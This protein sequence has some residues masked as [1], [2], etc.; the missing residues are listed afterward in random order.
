MNINEDSLIEDDSFSN[1]NNTVPNKEEDINE[2]KD[3]N[4]IRSIVKPSAN[5]VENAF[6]AI[7][8]LYSTELST[9]D[10]IRIFNSIITEQDPKIAKA[11]GASVN[12][13]EGLNIWRKVSNGIL[14]ALMYQS[15]VENE[16]AKQLLI[17]TGNVKFTHI[18][19]KGEIL[20]E[21]MEKGEPTGESRFANILTKIR[22]RLQEKEG[23]IIEPDSGL[24]KVQLNITPANNADKKASIKGSMAN[25]FIGFAD[26]INGS[27]TANYAKQAGEYANVGNYNSNDIIFVSIPGKRGDETVRH[28]QQNR[29][30]QECL[31]AIKSGATLLTDNKEYTENSNYNEGEK[32]LAEA[33]INAGA[34][35]SEV[36]KD[37]QKIGKWVM[38]KQQPSTNKKYYYYNSKPIKGVSVKDLKI[39]MQNISS[40]VTKDV[41][42]EDSDKTTQYIKYSDFKQG[43]ISEII[44]DFKEA[45]HDYEGLSYEDINKNVIYYDKSKQSMVVKS[46]AVFNVINL[47][48]KIP[49]IMQKDSWNQDFANVFECYNLGEFLYKITTEDGNAKIGSTINKALYGEKHIID[50]NQ[51]ELFNDQSVMTKLAESVGITV[52]Q[53]KQN[54][55][56]RQEFIQK[57]LKDYPTNEALD[58]L[59]DEIDEQC[60]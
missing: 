26:G 29:T 8:V 19:R 33:L 39:I 45:V 14:S 12:L 47:L 2:L 4:K 43:F 16:E 56:A 10:K 59:A 6:Q 55:E 54:L 28:E 38:V 23:Y 24:Q 57:S 36:E 42:G 41:L 25:K 37:G 17:N 21:I 11:K 32:R 60:K 48:K 18:N 7:K 22:T 5:T 34:T 15:F 13:G 30:I 52:E 3:I 58:A 46:K 35:Y 51:L 40:L 49:A 1:D 20:D 31:K 44:N 9:D 53:L 27:S 50:E